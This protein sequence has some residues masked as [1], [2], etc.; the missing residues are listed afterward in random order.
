MGQLFFAGVSWARFCQI[1]KQKLKFSKVRYGTVSP[2]PSAQ[3][4]RPQFHVQ[5]KLNFTSRSTTILRPIRSQFYVQFGLNPTS[6][7]TSIL[8]PIRSQFYVQFDL[9]FTSRSKPMGHVF[10]ADGTK[11]GGHETPT[12]DS[13]VMTTADLDVFFMGQTQLR[14]LRNIEF[15]AS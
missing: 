11:L 7:S 4:R 2:D 6:N 3:R 15:L 8:R 10:F 14:S 12:R 13:S 1:F 5:I 9:N